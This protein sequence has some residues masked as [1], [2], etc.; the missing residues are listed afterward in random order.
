[1][2][3]L[4]P[5]TPRTE[6]VIYEQHVHKQANGTVWLRERKNGRRSGE[7]LGEPEL[8]GIIAQHGEG[9]RRS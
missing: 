6:T 9:T 8:E 7:K 1:M 4:G 3:R 2:S 5:S